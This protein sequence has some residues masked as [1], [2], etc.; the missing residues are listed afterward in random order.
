MTCKST[1]LH[2][3]SFILREYGLRLGCLLVAFVCLADRPAPAQSLRVSSAAVPNAAANARMREDSDIDDLVA[4]LRNREALEYDV[5]RVPTKPRVIHSVFPEWT[6]ARY[7]VL[8]ITSDILASA[9]ITKT[10][11]ELVRRSLDYTDVVLLVD[12][13]DPLHSEH[14][15]AHLADARLLPAVVPFPT[16]TTPAS[17]GKIHLL[18]LK[19]NTKWVR[20]Y[21]PVFAK[22]E[23]G[24]T[25]LDSMYRDIRTELSAGLQ[26]D[27]SSLRRDD[28]TVPTLLGALI[29]SSALGAQMYTVR[30][31]L[32]L[33]GGDLFSDGAGTAFTSTSTLLMNGGDR[34]AF[35][36]L[37]NRYYGFKSV[38]YLEPLPGFT[39]KHV[40]MFFQVAGIRDGKHRFVV[41]EYDPTESILPYYSFLHREVTAVLERNVAKLRAHFPECEVTRVPLPGLD[42]S[43]DRYSLLY[44]S[45]EVLKDVQL[46]PE[47][48]MLQSLSS[49]GQ[50]ERLRFVDFA[51]SFAKAKQPDRERSP[52]G[53]EDERFVE[54]KTY[55]ESQM[56]DLARQYVE[57]QA[58]SK[59]KGSVEVEIQLADLEA[60]YLAYRDE[61]RP[62]TVYRTYLNALHIAGAGGEV[63]FVP[64]FKRHVD[65]EDVVRSRYEGAYPGAKVEFIPCDDLITQY[66]GLHCV[67]CV[68]PDFAPKP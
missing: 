8:S 7:L 2:R 35:E 64:S 36:R 17:H 14:L 26:S 51:A 25:V 34:R 57:L 62:R 5:F 32:Q 19:V 49:E 6:P 1:L 10:F 38:V 37:L 41:G 66:G 22:G 54:R 28:D 52:P 56:K 39:I 50:P 4:Q 67:S 20:D 48:W 43:P 40:D 63:V 65:R 21:G 12:D 16:E 29:P 47:A 68:V 58:N 3:R 53:T 27:S 15:L 13:R 11:V 45:M 44:D 42:F 18:P 24:F 59:D 46:S 60:K 61:L 33:W 55:L 31:P 23:D 9:A 30:P